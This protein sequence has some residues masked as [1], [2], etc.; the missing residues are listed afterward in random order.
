MLVP[1][2]Y[3]GCS[4]KIANNS[5]VLVGQFIGLDLGLVPIDLGE[6]VL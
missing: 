3:L 4:W 1:T 5:L 2:K 6:L